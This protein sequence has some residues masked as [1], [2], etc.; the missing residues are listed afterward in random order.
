MV[1]LS[2]C[3]SIVRLK[4]VDRGDVNLGS[5]VVYPKP[6]GA[7]CE[8]SMFLSPAGYGLK[9]NGFAMLQVPVASTNGLAK[10]TE[11]HVGPAPAVAIAKGALVRVC[12]ANSSSLRLK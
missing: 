11:P 2:S 3:R 7:N 10:P 8:K 12:S 6:M 4:F 9:G 5:C 1:A